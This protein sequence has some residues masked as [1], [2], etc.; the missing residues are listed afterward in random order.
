MIDTTPPMI[1][2]HANVTAEATGANGAVVSYSSPASHNAVS[3]DGIATCAPASGSTFALGTTTVACSAVDG[4]GN[5]GHSSFTVTVQDT[6]APTLTLPA[7]ITVDATSP[8]GA[9][10]VYA[11][12]ATDIVSGPVTVTCV[13]PSGSTFAIGTSTVSCTS[14]DGAG[15]PAIGSFQVLVQAAAAQVAN[16]IVTVQNFNLAQG[17]SNSLDAKLQ[18]ILSALSAAQGGSVTNTCNQLAAFI[19]QTTAQSGQRLTAARRLSSSPRRH[20]SKR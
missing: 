3:G 9:F 16:L 18:N 6:V 2:A 1:D 7:G 14:T 19:N 10:V 15:N 5:T 11:T 17:I 12:S 8:S 20:K 13:L 4:A